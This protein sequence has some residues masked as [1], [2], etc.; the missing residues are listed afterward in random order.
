MKV[1]VVGLGSMGRRRI[2]LLKQYDKNIHITGVDTNEE[3]ARE[4]ASEYRIE[5]CSSIEQAVDSSRP[6]QAAFVCT[7]PLSHKN[8]IHELLKFD[9]YIFTEINL[10]TDGYDE[11]IEKEKANKILFLSSTFLYRKD[12]AYIIEQV[13]M[14]KV[15]YC[16]H[17]GQYLPDWHPWESYN[18]FFVKDIRT[19][20]CREILA[21]EL[22][23]IIECFGGIKSFSVIKDNLSTLN[24]KYPDNYLLQIEHESGSK[25]Q[26][27]VDVIARKAMRRLEVYNENLQIFWNGTPDSLEMYNI[28]K[29][30]TEHIETYSAVEND[31]NYCEN[32]IENAYMDE[33]VAF[34][35][36]IRNGD[37]SFARHCFTR[38]KEILDFI[39]K[40]EK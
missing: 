3:R 10:V 40:L 8:I 24:L 7:S 26:I 17:T 22:P 32:I 4:V 28:E 12:I 11:F 6:P 30:C 2:R 14:Q 35:E 38:D 23:W 9:L 39:D 36:C 21:I 33:I 29:K 25:G 16:Y 15:N 34:F 19:N 18:E 1:I 31:S 5:I 37:M 20:G 27:L 13:K